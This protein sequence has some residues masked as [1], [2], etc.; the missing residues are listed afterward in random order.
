MLKK[1]V[2]LSMVI[3]IVFALS[4]CNAKDNSKQKEEKEQEIHQEVE[5]NSKTDEEVKEEVKEEVIPSPD[6]SKVQEL[7][8][9]IS[10]TSIGKVISFGRYE[11]DNDL[12]NGAEEIQWK[13][14]GKKGG[15]AFLLSTTLL[16]AMKHST[17]YK[18]YTQWQ[19]STLRK[20][21]NEEFYCEAFNQE[22]QVLI[23]TTIVKTPN[24]PEY[25]TDG[26][27]DTED[28]LFVLSLDEMITYFGLNTE[29]INPKCVA[30]MS[31]YAVAQ[32]GY[33]LTKQDAYS[34]LKGQYIGNGFWWLRTPGRNESNVIVI[35]PDGS[36][37]MEGGPMDDE[38]VGVRPAMWVNYV[39]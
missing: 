4:A 21:L 13:V 15:K 32:G 1:R 37:L 31:D 35:C 26:G 7:M 39:E 20:W 30:K 9:E 18:K 8:K 28:K 10:N 38:T 23:A 25:H 29:D 3:A 19:S 11:Q 36:M 27:V 33:A 24:N 12:S 5:D 6:M 34:L 22:E 16:N 2:I 17:N 14:I